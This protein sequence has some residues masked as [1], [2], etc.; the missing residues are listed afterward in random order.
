MINRSVYVIGRMLCNYR[1]NRA[2]E[3]LNNLAYVFHQRLNNVNFDIN[4]NGEMNVLNALKEQHLQCFFDV[5][6]NTGEWSKLVS[7][8]FP[9][10]RIHAFEVVPSTYE[11]L[12]EAT[13]DNPNIVVNNFG[14][15]DEAAAITLNIGEH[16]SAATAFKL[17]GMTYHDNYYT[18]EVVGNVK[19][20][21]DYVREQDIERI[22]FLKVD[23]EGMDLRV[24]KGFGENIKLARIIQF[25]YGIFNISSHD[26][27]WDFFKHLTAHDFIIGKVYPR[28]V[29][30]FDYFF[31]RENFYG[32]NYIA[33]QKDDEQLRALLSKPAIK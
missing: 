18:H 28:Y 27:L 19:T 26:L 17:E 32:G 12:K 11:Q 21:A 4:I 33:I 7:G 10:S 23:V 29:E 9:S 30:F 1:G 25:E 5:G 13:R 22:D 14:L 6:A 16:S 8:L 2:V 15:S 3:A 24:I 20:G 31:S